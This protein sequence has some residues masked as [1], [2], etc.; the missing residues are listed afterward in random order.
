MT[1]TTE[2][3]LPALLSSTQVAALLS[4]SRVSVY[5][6]VH[7]GQLHQPVRIGGLSRWRRREVELLIEGRGKLRRPRRRGEQAPE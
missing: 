2:K 6:L 3:L 1:T 4:I 5:R 7:R